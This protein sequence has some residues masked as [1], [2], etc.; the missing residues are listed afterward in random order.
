MSS[1]SHRVV[2]RAARLSGLLS[3]AVS[4]L[5]T[6]AS[7]AAAATSSDE[8]PR[9]AEAPRAA[10]SDEAP[11]AAP[12]EGT[13]SHVSEILFLTPEMGAEY[14][15]METLHL[16]HELLPSGAHTADIGPVVGVA[17]GVRLLFVTLGPR[18]RFGHFR[19]WDLWTLDA[20]VGFKVPLGALEPYFEVGA[21]YAKVGS[22]QDSRVRVQGY[23]LRLNFGLDYYFNKSFSIGG[24]ATAEMLGMTRP[25][26]DLN[27]ATGSVSQDVYKLDGSSVG[28][29]VMAS[30]VVGV[31]L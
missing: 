21:G 16:T 27:Q 6:F 23:D 17:G 28:L 13:V 31:H 2:G 25:G 14:V 15:G 5:A 30:A 11:H 18:F 24:A 3:C 9:T 10:A 12:S 22:L 4:V 26:V 19:D 20:E 8:G 29:A 1:S 7:P